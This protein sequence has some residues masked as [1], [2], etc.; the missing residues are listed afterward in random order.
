MGSE[1]DVHLEEIETLAT[2]IVEIAAKRNGKTQAV[3]LATSPTMKS[4][5]P[6]TL[7]SVLNLLVVL[8]YV[9]LEAIK[10]LGH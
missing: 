10:R 5:L 1:E 4:K 2:R 7:A 9:I 8:G 6:V 3:V